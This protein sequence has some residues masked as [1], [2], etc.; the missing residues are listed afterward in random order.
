MATLQ[1]NGWFMTCEGV[2][3][4]NQ[5]REKGIPIQEIPPN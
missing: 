5:N 2:S 4:G 1:E 3:I